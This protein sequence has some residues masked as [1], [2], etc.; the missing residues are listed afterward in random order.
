M[1]RRGLLVP[2]RARHESTDSRPQV[3]SRTVR[4]LAKRL[5]ARLVRRRRAQPAAERSQPPQARAGSV[6]DAKPRKKRDIRDAYPRD[7]SRNLYDAVDFLRTSHVN[8]LNGRLEERIRREIQ[9]G[10][11]LRTAFVVNDRAKWNASALLQKMQSLGWD[12]RIHLCLTDVKGLGPVERKA[13]YLEQRSFFAQVDPDLVDLYDPENDRVVPVEEVSA[14]IVFYQQPWGMKDF[15]RRMAGRALGAY[16]HYGFILMANHGMHYHIGSFHSYL[17]RYFTQTEEHRLLHLEHDPS[18]YDKLVVTGYPKLDVYRDTSPPSEPSPIWPEPA[19]VAKRVIFAPH[20]SLGKDNLQMSTFRWTHALMLELA[21][22]EPGLQWVYKP[23]PNL[24]HSVV[25][26]KVMTAEEYRDYE[27]S[28]AALP[29]C[30]VYDSGE[31]FDIF[32]SSDVLITDCG[33]F[34]AEYLPTGNPIIWL[35]SQDTV[36]LNPVGQKLSEGFYQARDIEDVR[37]LFREVVLDGHDPLEP[38]RRKWISALLPPGTDATNQVLEHLRARFYP[39][40][41][42]PVPAQNLSGLNG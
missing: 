27:R 21:R 30:T 19:H 5:A 35:I 24:Q 2:W 40:G 42:D 33:S 29:N 20:H 37:R 31:Y 18:A 36:G 1:A 13:S 17:W 38:E 6:S 10:R 3:S 7:S 32:K 25:K 26:N 28:W 23:H 11:Q 9:D 16:M 4:T 22:S 12:A 39:A 15:P 8:E 34:L 41:R 14:D